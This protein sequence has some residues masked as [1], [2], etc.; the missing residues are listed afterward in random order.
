MS[1]SEALRYAEEV[2]A[3]I[4]RELARREE[5]DARYERECEEAYE[6][7][8]EEVKEFFDSEE[9]KIDEVHKQEFLE[10]LW[11][12]YYENELERLQRGLPY[13]VEE[14]LEEYTEDFT[15]EYTEEICKMFKPISEE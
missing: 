10:Y 3:G 2:E 8:R 7:L 5:A 13:I 9:C 1:Y 14:F 12:Y 15:E 6:E 11:K 4:D